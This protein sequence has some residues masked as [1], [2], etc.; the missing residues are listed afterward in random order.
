MRR[1]VCTQEANAF[2]FEYVHCSPALLR[3]QHLHVLAS[4]LTLMVVQNTE[5]LGYTVNGAF[6]L[7]STHCLLVVL[8]LL[9]HRTVGLYTRLAGWVGGVAFVSCAFNYV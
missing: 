1:P 7:R 5:A 3:K 9:L 2:A 4:L 8:V 6:L